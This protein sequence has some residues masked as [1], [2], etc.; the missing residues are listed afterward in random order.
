M[1]YSFVIP[2]LLLLAATALVV[3]SLRSWLRWWGFAF[4]AAG[5]LGVLMASGL[6]PW[7]AAQTSNYL[8]AALD[9]V[10]AL[11]V[12]FAVDV[13]GA[14]LGQ[15]FQFIL[16]GSTPAAILGA[17]LLVVELVLNKRSPAVQ[18]PVAPQT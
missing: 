12:D 10:P 13:L 7:I 5:V 3:R 9:S 1:R 2:V 8:V 4:L 14:L 11:F 15:A 16:R 6:T 17:I 18:M